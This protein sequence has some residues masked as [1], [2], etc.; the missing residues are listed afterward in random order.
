MAAPKWLGSALSAGASAIGGILGFAGQNR[1]NQANERLADK[2]M[3]FQMHMSST[4]VRRR[5]ADL[6]AAGINPILAGTFDASTPAGA[7]AV[8]GNAGLA[9]AQGASIGATAARDVQTLQ[10]DIGAL[11]ARLNLTR[12]QARAIGL[13]AEASSNA[14]E[15]LG[16]LIEKAKEFSLSELDI[17]NMIQMV[18]NSLADMTRNLLN[19]IAD[20]LEQQ[21]GEGAGYRDVEDYR[22]DVPIGTIPRN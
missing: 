1:A 8:H 2:Q 15:F 22:L 6:K 21:L 14:G 4:A 18:P 3:D 5:M 16:V 10:H 13:V 12:E 17:E 11:K 9:G 19:G 20:I 7:M